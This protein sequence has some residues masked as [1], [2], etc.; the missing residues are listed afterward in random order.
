MQTD[1]KEQLSHKSKS[2]H[3]SKRGIIIEDEERKSLIDSQNDL[4]A[5]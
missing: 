3:S 1:Q 4:G 2:N 5:E